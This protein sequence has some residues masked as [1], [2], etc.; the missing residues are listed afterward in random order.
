MGKY[1][2]FLVDADDTIF[3]F[4]AAAAEAL[5]KTFAECSLPYSDEVYSAYMEINDDLWKKLE[6]KEI[7]QSELKRLR[8]T[9]VLKRLNMNFPGEDM[10]GIYIKNLGEC[11]VIFNGAEEF[12]DELCHIGD[13]YIITNGF[14]AVQEKRLKKFGI[15]RYA[16]GVFVSEEVGA[17]KPDIK[18]LEYVKARIPSYKREK[19]LVIGDSLTSDIALANAGGID[20]VWYN[21]AGKPLTGG[22]KV[23][24][25]ASD[26][27]EV[28]SFIKNS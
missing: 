19:T 28:L 6:R 13:V 4:K 23:T 9:L 3:D 14:K 26:Y 1:E 27:A 21:T 8:F 15:E 20:C 10:N 5:K 25:T 18:Y 16:K 2:V 22:K 11:A 12:L 24:F 17:N 7:D